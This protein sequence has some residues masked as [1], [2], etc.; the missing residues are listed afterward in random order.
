MEE[1]QRYQVIQDDK[2]YIISTRLIGDKIRLECQDN[3]FESS[4]VYS[5]DYTLLELTS[6]SE[7][8]NF[9]PS[10]VEVQNELN[11]SIERQEVKITNEGEYIEIVFNVKV[12]SYSQELTFQ[13]PMKQTLEPTYYQN[14]EATTAAPTSTP[15]SVKQP[16][17][18]NAYNVNQN[19]EQDDYPDVTYST[20]PN[21]PQQI[22]QHPQN[23]IGCGC[24]QD[25]DRINKIEENSQILRMEHDDIRKRINDLKMMIQMIKKETSDLRA[26]NGGLNMKTLDLKKQYNNLI[27]AEAALRGENDEI[28]RENHELMLKKNELGFYINE[29]HD[30][31]TVREVNIPLDNKRRRLTNVSKRE[32][33]FGGGYSSSTYKQAREAGYSS[34]N[35]KQDEE[36]G[37]SS[38]AYKQTGDV[39]YSSAK[40]GN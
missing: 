16:L 3:N 33:Q 6:F 31:D 34:S 18:K 20:K 8:F 9:T 12:N 10:V 29:H 7:I 28:R 32:K 35:Y 27:E 40:Y 24:L 14:Q 21:L 23:D 2:D 5:R 11:N 39:G 26:E 38:G 4:P 17:Y 25:H 19:I 36:P 30:H 13:L 37:Y 15:V 22:Y 1:A